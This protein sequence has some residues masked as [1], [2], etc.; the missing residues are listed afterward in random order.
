[1]KHLLLLATSLS[2]AASLSAAVEID[3]DNATDL[4]Q[5]VRNSPDGPGFTPV[6]GATAGLGGAGGVDLSSADRRE[7]FVYQSGFALTTGTPYA[8]SGYFQQTGDTNFAGVGFTDSVSSVGGYAM[9][10]MFLLNSSIS[11]VYLANYTTVEQDWSRYNT[12]SDVLE[13][14]DWY[15]SS[16]SLLYIGADSFTVDILLQRS[17]ADGTLGDVLFSSS[18]TLDNPALAGAENL[19]AFFYVDAGGDGT[20]V[21]AFDSF[22]AGEVAPVV[23]EPAETGLALGLAGLFGLGLR[24]WR[25]Q[26]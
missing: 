3:F 1:M 2:I 4:D 6:V 17:A 21:T 8:V 11:E 24:R 5:F 19:F 10:P 13:A 26:A 20:P 25:K 9:D 14:G 12:F 7:A 16:L 22:R 15:Y 18:Y 23:P